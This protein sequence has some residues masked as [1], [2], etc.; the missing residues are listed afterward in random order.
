MRAYTACLLILP[1]VVVSAVALLTVPRRARA[2]DT[3]SEGLFWDEATLAFVRAK[4][5]GT[6]VDSLSE[7]QRVSFD[8]EPSSKGPRAGN[9]RSEG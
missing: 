2:A 6:Y 8:E 4:V 5:S 9:V 1:M 7:G 3:R